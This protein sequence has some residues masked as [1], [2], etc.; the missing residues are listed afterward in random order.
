MK[1]KIGIVVFFMGFL[2][3][4]LGIYFLIQQNYMG[5]LQ[6]GVGIFIII[7]EIWLIKSFKKRAKEREEFFRKMRE[8]LGID[9]EM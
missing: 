6:I 7:M 3:I 4:S 5:F 8:R 1:N 2:N 9:E